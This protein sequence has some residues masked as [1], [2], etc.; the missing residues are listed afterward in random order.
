MKDKK[1]INKNK[2]NHLFDYH[3]SDPMSGARVGLEV[4]IKTFKDI[5]YELH[6]G[7]GSSQYTVWSDCPKELGREIFE[8]L[9]ENSIKPDEKYS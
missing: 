2:R 7:G 6:F 4:L 8:K 5:G 1:N 9:I 3:F